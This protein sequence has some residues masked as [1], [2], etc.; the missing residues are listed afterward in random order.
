VRPPTVTATEADDPA[1]AGEVHMQRARLGPYFFG[2]L[3]LFA[4]ALPARANGRAETSVTDRVVSGL[5]NKRIAVLGELPSHGEG[6]AFRLKADIVEA[7]VLRCGFDAVLFE[8]PIYDFIGLESRWGKELATPMQLNQAIGRFWWAGQLA[9]FR[10]WLFDQ[11]NHN[12]LEVGGLDD[13]ISIT[14]EYARY[15]LPK[16]IAASV[17]DDEAQACQASVERN[18][19]WTYDDSH[20]WDDAEKRLLLNCAQATART[21][22]LTTPGVATG[23]DAAV[24]ANFASYVQRQT[25]TRGAPD[26]DMTMFR[27]VLWHL[28]RLPPDAKVIIWTATVHGARQQGD[29]ADKP[30][31]ERLHDQWGSQLG[32]V[33]VTAF[34]GQSSMAG[35]PPTPLVAASR[36][37]LEGRAMRSGASVAYIDAASLGNYGEVES[38]LF[39]KFSVAD[40]STRFD[41]VIVV[42]EEVPAAFEELH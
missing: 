22:G 26:R 29:L 3:V 30:L 41:G 1:Q 38:R 6:R 40:W 8:A 2:F 20:A 5:C 13:Q 12:R 34:S 39:G 31:G 37:S 17:P 25:E 10:R 33:G 9:D 18:L 21:A 28:K 19:K 35:R 7:L 4:I 11:A 42:R 27:N 23:E 15:A 16:L 32:T 36:Q 14:S 24:S